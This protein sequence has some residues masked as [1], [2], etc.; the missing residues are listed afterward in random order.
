MGFGDAYSPQK[1]L[2]PSFKWS[3]ANILDLETQAW[4]R[5]GKGGLPDGHWPSFQ[6]CCVDNVFLRRW[7]G[8]R[9]ML[10]CRAAVSRPQGP[11]TEALKAH[12][13][14]LRWQSPQCRGV[15]RESYFRTVPEAGSRDSSRVD[16]CRSAFPWLAGSCLLP[17]SSHGFPLVCVCVRS[18]FSRVRLPATPWTVAHQAPLSTGFTRQECWSELPCP[19][20]GHLPDPGIKLM[21]P[22]SQ[23]DSLHWA[24]GEAPL[25]G[26]ICVQIASS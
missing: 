25:S 11:G 21:S 16:F 24:T 6:G 1:R 9:P 14:L 15:S 5:V 19:S 2:D 8:E 18:C 22:A 13:S 17:A 7:Q 23:V 12:N 26:F 4:R 10:A 20:P 3:I